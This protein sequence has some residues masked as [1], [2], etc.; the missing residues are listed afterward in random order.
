M[1]CRR[2]Q[3]LIPLYVEGDL[4]TG[5]AARVRSHLEECSECARVSSEYRASQQWLRSYTPPDFEADF[6]DGLRRGV[7]REIE[8]GRSRR[9]WFSL[10]DPRLALK[11]A[12]LALASLVVVGASIGL[13]LYVHPGMKNEEVPLYL[14]GDAGAVQVPG[15]DNRAPSD[16]D[17]GLPDPKPRSPRRAPKRGAARDFERVG[18]GRAALATLGESPSPEPFTPTGMGGEAPGKVLR[19]ELQTGDPNI[20]IIWFAPSESNAEDSKLIINAETE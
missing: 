3:G 20:R 17:W 5:K 9:P 19:I 16:I 8:A 2:I 6:F 10:F 14:R 18:E 12:S 7:L 13:A 1:N 15:L 11:P 4:N